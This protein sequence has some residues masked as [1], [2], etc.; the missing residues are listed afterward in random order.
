MIPTGSEAAETTR[1][2]DIM[3]ISRIDRGMTVGKY[4][5]VGR[6][7]VDRVRLS[8]GSPS[9]VGSAPVSVTYRKPDAGAVAS[10]IV[11]EQ[12]KSEVPAEKINRLRDLVQSGNYHVSAA[13][14]ANAMLYGASND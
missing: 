4:E 7:S 12:L 8:S 13:K 10:Q 6:E 11:K 9:A 5:N 2:S 14:I 3:D 1:G